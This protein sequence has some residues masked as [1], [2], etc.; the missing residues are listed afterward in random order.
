[1]LQHEKAIKYLKEAKFF[2]V[3]SVVTNSIMKK[4][5][6]DSMIEMIG[7]VKN[8]TGSND[9]SAGEEKAVGVVRTF[10]NSN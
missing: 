10:L 7:A 2:A 6:N 9:L 8:T 4:L 5:Y 1:M 3:K